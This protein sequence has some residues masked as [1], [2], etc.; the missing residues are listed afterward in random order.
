MFDDIRNKLPG[1]LAQIVRFFGWTDSETE[2]AKQ[3]RKV[4][5]S[6]VLSYTVSLV[7]SAGYTL[8]DTE[9]LIAALWSKADAPDDVP[10]PSQE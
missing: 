6:A 5:A 10:H 1:A 7:R 3:W 8:A 2:V 4:I 9:D